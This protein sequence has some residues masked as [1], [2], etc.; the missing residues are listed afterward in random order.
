MKDYRKLEVS[1]RLSSYR[2]K[3]P[4]WSGGSAVRSPFK[5]WSSGGSLPWYQAYNRTKHNRHEHFKDAN[6]GA[7][8]D[9][10]CGLTILHSAQ[11]RNED[12][13][14][15]SYLLWHGGSKDGFDEA[16]G[17]YFLVAYP[18]DWP[19]N[20]RYEFDWGQLQKSPDPFQNYD[21]KAI[22]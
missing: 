12:F 4:L 21:Y 16:A 2:A 5:A 13:E 15:A 10:M 20:E 19:A 9:A 6:F 8:V 3:L 7:L 22:P 11:F 17:R 1:H 18:D 14:R